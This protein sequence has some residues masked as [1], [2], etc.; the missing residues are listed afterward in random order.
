[1]RVKEESH[2]KWGFKERPCEQGNLE[3]GVEGVEGLQGK[4]W[5]EGPFQAE[6]TI[7]K[8]CDG[9]YG[10][11]Q[12]TSSLLPQWDCGTCAG[13]SKRSLDQSSHSQPYVGA[14]ECQGEAFPCDLF[15]REELLS[16]GL[17]GGLAVIPFPPSSPWHWVR[18]ILNL[19]RARDILSSLRCWEDKV[20]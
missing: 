15:G 2:W 12:E 5:R 13:S 10:C 8:A 20:R 16:T 14:S 9:G 4:S 3:T 17:V 18:G 11:I 7:T 19:Q 6:D 1:M